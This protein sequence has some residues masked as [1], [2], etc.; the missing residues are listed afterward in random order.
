MSL[1]TL[2]VVIPH[3]NH[4]HLVR[5]AVGAMLA[6]SV[7]PL[8]IIIVDDASTD[9]SKPTLHELAAAHPCLRVIENEQNRGVAFSSNRGVSL[10]RGDYVYI[11]AADDL[12]LPGFFGKTMKLARDYPK[13]GIIYGKMAMVDAVGAILDMFE[14]SAWQTARFATPQQF[15]RQHLE[16][17]EPTHS[18][19]GATI[20]QRDA[21]LTVGGFRAE[22][23]HWM[24][25]FAARAI[26][27]RHGVCYAP[28]PF[29]KW[30]WSEQSFCGRSRW[31]ERVA[32][33]RRA[34]MLMRSAPFNEVFPA[35][36]VAWWEKASLEK[37]Y[38]ERVE[39]RWPRLG[40]FRKAGGWR[41]RIAS[42]CLRAMTR[43]PL[44]SPA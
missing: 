11:A 39:G 37:L 25:S 20:Y 34:A 15:L 42:W 40:R 32:I 19:C 21:L 41:S 28:E 17:E 31:D 5:N 24:D 30:R 26:G 6:Q 2:S 10:C 14:V 8:E 9:G 4:G 1:P 33:V 18:L 12:V 13:A 36:H 22:L 44:G 7:P 29:M 43:R 3:Y 38:R 27:L 35:D 16:S 23:G